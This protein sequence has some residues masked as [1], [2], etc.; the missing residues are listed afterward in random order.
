MPHR[1]GTT[2]K[3]T[4]HDASMMQGKSGGIDAGNSM[5]QGKSGDMNAGNSMKPTMMDLDGNTLKQLLQQ[6]KGKGKG[7]SSY[8]IKSQ[9]PRNLRITKSS[10]NHQRR[11]GKGSGNS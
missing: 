7:S 6:A 10:D 3:P 2:M 8:G 9:P 1:N 4:A 5:M 11:Y